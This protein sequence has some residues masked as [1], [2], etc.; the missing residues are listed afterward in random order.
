MTIVYDAALKRPGCVLLQAAM[1]GDVPNF[2]K[3]F[4]AETWLTAPTPG[5]RA[6]PVTA[7]QLSQLVRITEGSRERG[8]VRGDAPGGA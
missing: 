7:E 1:G 8:P 2:T 6:Y 5:M 3:L 4:A